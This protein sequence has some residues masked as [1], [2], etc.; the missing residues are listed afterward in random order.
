MLF[1]KS[2]QHIK[3]RHM[4]YPTRHL[5]L[6][7]EPTPEVVAGSFTA[8]FAAMA[9]YIQHGAAFHSDLTFI[10]TKF[11]LDTVAPCYLNKEWGQTEDGLPFVA[12]EMFKD[13]YPNHAEDELIT[14]RQIQEL[15]LTGLHT[16]EKTLKIPVYYGDPVFTQ[17]DNKQFKVDITG[18]KQH[19]SFITGQ[20]THFYIW[21]K[22]PKKYY[23][24]GVLQR[25]LT[26]I[27]QYPPDAFP[28]DMDIIVVGGGLSVIWLAKHFATPDTTRR[29]ICLKH[30]NVQLIKDVPA[31]DSVDYSRIITIDLDKAD[32]HLAQDDPHFAVIYSREHNR[33]FKG[34]FFSAIGVETPE[35][36]LPISQLTSPDQWLARRWISAKNIP[37]GSLME[38]IARWFAITDNLKWGFEP[39]S[40]H[41]ATDFF[42]DLLKTHFS[43]ELNMDIRY[44]NALGNAVLGLAN[45]VPESKLKGFLTQIYRDVYNPTDLQLTLFEKDIIK[46]LDQ[47]LKIMDVETEFSE[48][49]P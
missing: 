39:Q 17:L 18:G 42:N 32:I 37:I 9:S 23:I 13:I 25:P 44:L 4:L 27:Y 43:P 11:W 41:E 1:F 48:F 30:S 12:R 8:I 24:H 49:T 16:L 29:I 28:N 47:R 19:T 20:N 14:W 2:L 35:H 21:N 46:L 34:P 31:N 45:P 22:Q 15:R 40:Y 3:T 5:R 7:K 10:C 6:F 36:H 33:T 38:S 26:D